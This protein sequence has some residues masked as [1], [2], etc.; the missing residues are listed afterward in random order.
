MPDE[1]NSNVLWGQ[2]RWQQ[3]P[4][5]LSA[6]TGGRPAWAV[7]GPGSQTCSP[8]AQVSSPRHHDGPAP[9]PFPPLNSKSPPS[10]P[11]PEATAQSPRPPPPGQNRAER[12]VWRWRKGHF[13]DAVGWPEALL[14]RYHVHM[15]HG[16]VFLIPNR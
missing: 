7:S 10:E 9:A 8:S 16:A 15:H 12:V 3:K 14:L 4:R 2:K 6:S 11:L 13:V 1:P 5:D